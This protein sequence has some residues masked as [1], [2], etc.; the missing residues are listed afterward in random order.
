MLYWELLDSETTVTASV[1]A[2]QL[3]NLADAMRQKRPGRE[4]VYLLHDNEH[5]QENPGDKLG[6]SG[7]ST[8]LSRPRPF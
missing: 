1:Y 5:P 6:S 7:P 8:V 4:N 3:Q 2:I